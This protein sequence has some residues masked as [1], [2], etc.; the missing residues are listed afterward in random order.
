MYTTDEETITLIFWL[1]IKSSWQKNCQINCCFYRI[2]LKKFH[3]GSI[4]ASDP[5]QYSIGTYSDY[6]IEKWDRS[7]F[8]S[9]S[10]P[11]SFWLQ[12]TFCIV[13]M[14]H[15]KLS[16]PVRPSSNVK[17]FMRQF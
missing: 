13:L 12:A 4:P 11:F 14:Q 15:Y 10:V 5:V 3:Y 6:L 8:F 16:E 9:M 2:W 1:A 7:D 17:L